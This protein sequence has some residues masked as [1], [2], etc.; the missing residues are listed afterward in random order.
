MTRE[1]GGCHEIRE[2][3]STWPSAGKVLKFIIIVNRSGSEMVTITKYVTS[4]F[5][6]DDIITLH[7][8]VHEH[9]IKDIVSILV[10]VE[11]DI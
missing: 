8:Q 5:Q 10:V 11:C 1:E 3:S 6:H 2:M 9:S 7:A 4:N